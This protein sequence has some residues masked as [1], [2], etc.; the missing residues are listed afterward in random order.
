[1]HP[2]PNKTQ[3]D[4]AVARWIGEAAG[5]LDGASL[6]RKKATW[7]GHQLRILGDR[8]IRTPEHL[9]GLTVTDLLAAQDALRDAAKA[10]GKAALDEAA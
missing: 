3:M 10:H 2:H 1:M 7:V 4:A 6:L 9:E 8:L 5:R